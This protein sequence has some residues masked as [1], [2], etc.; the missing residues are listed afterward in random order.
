MKFYQILFLLTILL[1]YNSV[2]PQ[3]NPEKKYIEIVPDKNFNISGFRK[4]FLGNDWRKLWTT[5]FK[6][7]ILNLNNFY[8][9]LL[10]VQKLSGYDSRSIL[11][12]SKKG[13][14]WKFSSLKFDP[15][16]IF[17]KGV[18]ENLSDRTLLDQISIINPFAPLVMNS[19]VNGIDSSNKSTLLVFIPDNSSLGKYQNEFGGLPG[20]LKNQN[21]CIDQMDSSD[22]ID[23]YSLLK[24]IESGR[25]ERVDSKKFLEER[26]I[27]IFSGDWNRGPEKWCWKRNEKEN[28]VT[29]IPVP[30]ERTLAF[31]KIDGLF[32]K[33]GV[34]LVPQL[35][36]FNR[37]YPD[38]KK[39]TYS[40]RYLD[41]KILTG[42]DKNTW[43][44]VTN[45]LY[46]KLSDSLI[47]NSVNKMP[48]GIT[49]ESDKLKEDL[50]ARRNNLSEISDDFYNLINKVADIY[51]TTKNDSA[52][53]DRLNNNFTEVSLFKESGKA[54]KGASQ[55][56]FK[57]I[58]NN[59]IT[60][61]IRIHLGDGDDKAV[62]NGKVD[63]SPL[64]RII[65]GEGNDELKDYSVVNGYLFSFI[66]IPVSENQ[67]E[68]YQGNENTILNSTKI[69]PTYYGEYSVQVN[70][71]DGYN[72]TEQKDRGHEWLFLPEF[73]Y[74]QNNGFVFGG[75]PL[76]YKYDYGYVPFKYRMSLTASYATRS[77]SINIFYNGNF[78][79]LI[80][81]AN[82]GLNFKKSE[83]E[84]IKFFGYGNE[85]AFNKE[86]DSKDF[87]L[88]KQKLIGFYPD[89][90]FKISRILSYTL[91]FSLENS[92][93][94]LRNSETFLK[95][96]PYDR[97]G[98]GR[99][100]IAGINSSIEY[101]YGDQIYNTFSGYHFKL[102]QEYFPKLLDSRNDFTKTSVDIRAF[103][104]G[105]I[106]TE[107]T[108]AL[109][110]GGEKIWGKFP[111]FKSV[112]LGGNTNLPGYSRER[113]AGNA[114]LFGQFE[115]RFFIKEIEFLLKEKLGMSLFSEAGRVF[116]GSGSSKKW[117]PSYGFGF[118]SSIIQKKINLSLIF[119]FSPEGMNM[120]ADTRFLF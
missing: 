94:S 91:G 36:S 61:E 65:G 111:L 81:N 14:L 19:I 22:I 71:K 72:E 79:S 42:I 49:V 5:P 70:K 55:N 73:S 84:L 116:S 4:F 63:E 88:L 100:N 39:I 26:L 3:G 10:P 107:T 34:V 9:G 23:T 75:G 31:S 58:F 109:R 27:D 45:D 90:Y 119:A 74:D 20:F 41:R 18:V 6:I 114:S 76:L 95:D 47:I 104:T 52:V 21:G 92:D 101:N 43:D 50:I 77:Q 102:T 33:S 7:Q 44:S 29:W 15:E 28:G 68:F 103:F 98:I 97:Y 48:L 59:K 105:N 108:F 67:T 82:V 30:K 69:T 24:K 112:F 85:T 25:D 115:L 8:G 99:F 80:N 35:C 32:G 120:Y 53:V 106:F 89:I 64:V 1:F 51:A 40:A 118:W 38:I 110:G 78:Y 113:F 93:V 37:D 62:I 17:P 54:R 96:F 60:D 16:R 12:R 87:Y 11:F 117:H 2:F 13:N 57:K 46:L 56:Y 86:L 83:L 66:P